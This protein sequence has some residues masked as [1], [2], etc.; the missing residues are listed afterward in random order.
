MKKI[1]SQRGYPPIETHDMPTKEE[2][3]AAYVH[4]YISTDY[5]FYSRHN[6]K[7]YS[8]DE[9][10]DVTSDALRSR[11]FSKRNWATSVLEHFGLP[12]I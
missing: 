3:I 2:W 12:I 8:C 6:D 1:R 10:Y 5:R 11:F 7:I 9:L 4:M